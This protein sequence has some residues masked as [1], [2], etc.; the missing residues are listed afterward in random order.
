MNL[1]NHNC[2][3]NVEVVHF[4]GSLTDGGIK[5]LRVSRELV[6]DNRQIPSNGYQPVP[7]NAYQPLRLLLTDTLLK[8]SKK[9]S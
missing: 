3:S 1:T 7:I 6:R 5:I 8:N 9:W 2:L 4:T